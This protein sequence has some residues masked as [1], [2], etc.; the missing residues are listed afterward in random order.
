MERSGSGVRDIGADEVLSRA[1]GG[2]ELR[3][4]GGGSSGAGSG[5]GGS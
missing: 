4:E 3:G 5:G 2:L 1:M